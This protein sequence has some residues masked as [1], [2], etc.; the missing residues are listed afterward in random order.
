VTLASGILVPECL[1]VH[2]MPSGEVMMMPELEEEEPPTATKAP[3]PCV[4]S[5]S[6]SVPGVLAV[7]VIPSG[8]VSTVAEELSELSVPP[9]ATKAPLP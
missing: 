1:R 4:M 8:E 3:F 7:H 6:I 5:Q 2:V 9:T